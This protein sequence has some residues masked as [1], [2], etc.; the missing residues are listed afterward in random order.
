MQNEYD[1]EHIAP[2]MRVCKKCNECKPLA[3]FKYKLTRAQA[4]QQG[5]AGNHLVIAEGKVCKDCRPKRK[6]LGKLTT[7]ELITKAANGDVHP[8]VAKS[9]IELI[10]KKALALKS[11]GSAEHWQKVWAGYMKDILAPLTEE[12]ARAQQAKRYSASIGKT[13]RADFYAAYLTHLEKLKSRLM[14]DQR[15]NPKEPKL[16]RWEE[17]FDEATAVQLRDDFAALPMQDRLNLRT[18]PTMVKYRYIGAP[19]NKFQRPRR[20]TPAERLNLGESK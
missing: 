10:K 4:K 9:R 6:P 13:A 2:I 3:L 7:K 17:Y 11:R 18:L 14:H 16:C 15:V 19:D 20:A 12:I 1:S 5:Y 8:F